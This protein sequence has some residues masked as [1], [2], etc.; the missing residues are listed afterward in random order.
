MPTTESPRADLNSRQDQ[1]LASLEPD[2]L[3]TAKHHFPRRSLRGAEV[4]LLWSLRLYLL[5]MIAV[6]VYQIWAGT[7]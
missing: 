1:V 2:Q 7:K 4:L 3:A 5:F 6:V